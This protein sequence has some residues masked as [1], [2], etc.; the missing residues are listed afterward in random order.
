[1]S[2]SSSKL[3]PT[4][5]LARPYAFNVVKYQT[6]DTPWR[7][8]EQRAWRGPSQQ[9]G[10]RDEGEWRAGPS[11]GEWAGWRRKL[12]GH[13]VTSVCTETQKGEQERTSVAL[14]GDVERGGPAKWPART[15]GTQ[16]SGWVGSPKVPQQ[17]AWYA[18]SRKGGTTSVRGGHTEGG[19]RNQRRSRVTSSQRTSVWKASHA[20][21]HNEWVGWYNEQAGWYNKWVGR[22]WTQAVYD[23]GAG[24]AARRALRV[25]Q[26][27][28][29]EVWRWGRRAHQGPGAANGQ[30]E[31]APRKRSVAA[32]GGKL[33]ASEKRS[34]CGGRWRN[35]VFR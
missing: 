19:S 34:G 30:E 29:G 26:L 16:R 12:A 27:E 6:F 2:E 5:Y 7:L 33:P 15:G 14:S 3:T 32:Y 23:R 18:P 17:Q 11:A 13:S 4:V 8:M 21:R 9:R 20:A 35:H 31:Q 10:K 1:M 22:C 28:H 25:A 24:N